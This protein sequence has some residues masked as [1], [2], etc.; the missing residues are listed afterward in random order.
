MG[1][2]KKVLSPKKCSHQMTSTKTVLTEIFPHQIF[3]HPVRFLPYTGSVWWRPLVGNSATKFFFSSLRGNQQ[4]QLATGAPSW[5]IPELNFFF[6]A[7]AA[8]TY[9]FRSGR[10]RPL[11]TDSGTNFFFSSC[12]RCYHVLVPL[13][14]VA[15][16]RDGFRN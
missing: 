13:R 6:L 11:V 4:L 14:T 7:C 10:W 1:F 15:P 2:T 12:L 8:I 5:R 16:P 3:S 9:S